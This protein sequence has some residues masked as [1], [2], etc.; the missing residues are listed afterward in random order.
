MHATVLILKVKDTHILK[1]IKKNCQRKIHLIG[2]QRNSQVVFT[3]KRGLP[4]HYSFTREAS[5]Q[6]IMKANWELFPLDC[7]HAATKAHA[8]WGRTRSIY[9][10][11]N[12]LDKLT[13]LS[14]SIKIVGVHLKKKKIKQ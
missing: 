7:F 5:L 4:K 9:S 6:E 11:C 2:H 13:R 10:Y 8:D 3:G 12:A 1:K 14:A